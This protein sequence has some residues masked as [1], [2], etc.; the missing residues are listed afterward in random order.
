MKVKGYNARNVNTKQNGKQ[1]FRHT[2]NQSMKAKSFNAHI[3]NTKKHENHTFRHTSN[4]SMKAKSSYADVEFVQ[5]YF[6]GK[7][8]DKEKMDKYF[9]KAKSFSH[10]SV[11][12]YQFQLNKGLFPYYIIIIIF[13]VFYPGIVRGSLNRIVTR[14]FLAQF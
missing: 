3:V 14:N 10:T 6:H 11:V 9:E 13:G 2:S 5:F 8:K 4:Q 12:I 1:T 7:L